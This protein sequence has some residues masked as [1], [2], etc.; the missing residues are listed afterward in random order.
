MEAA[1]GEDR[2]AQPGFGI[3]RVVEG[4]V[5]REGGLRSVRCRSAETYDETGSCELETHVYISV[6]ERVIREAGED[7]SPPERR[8]GARREPE[9]VLWPVRLARVGHRVGLAP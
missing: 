2:V 8:C 3:P 1:V 4:G 5:D 9:L 6:G 7:E